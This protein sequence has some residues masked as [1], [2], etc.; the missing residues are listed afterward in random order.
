MARINPID[1]ACN[2]VPGKKHHRVVRYV[3]GSQDNIYQNA[4]SNAPKLAKHLNPNGPDGKPRPIEVR[5]TMAFSG[6]IAELVVLE[7]LNRYFLNL[8]KTGNIKAQPVPQIIRNRGSFNQIDIAVSCGTSGKTKTIEVRS[9]NI[10]KKD[11]EQVYNRDQ[12]LIGKYSTSYKR[13]ELPK[14]YYVTVFFR[15]SKDDLQTIKQKGLQVILDIAGGA[16]KSFMERYGTS[17]DMGQEGA[18]YQI[19]KPIIQCDSIDDLARQIYQSVK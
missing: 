6:S 18:L 5:E 2:V 3:L 10:I 12:S 16:S 15:H 7:Y 9:S 17:S 13:N 14:D 19:V 8:D 1:I 4:L 11:D